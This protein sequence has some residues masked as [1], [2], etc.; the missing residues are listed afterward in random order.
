MS[1][2]LSTVIVALFAGI[3]SFLGSA[4]GPYFSRQSEQ[5]KMNLE[6]VRYATEDVDLNRAAKNLLFW[7]QVGMLK[8]PDTK[9]EADVRKALKELATQ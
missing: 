6:L 9:T 5:D 7:Y 8:L 1:K 2:A 4:V 3:A